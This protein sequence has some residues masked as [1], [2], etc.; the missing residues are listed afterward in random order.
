[1]G[2]GNRMNALLVEILIAVLFFALSATVILETFVAADRLSDSAGRSSEALAEAQNWAGR[3][4]ASENAA[5]LLEES[6]FRAEDGGWTMDCGE[7]ALTVALTE[8]EMAAG[9]MLSAE[10]RAGDGDGTL[11]TLPCARYFPGEVTP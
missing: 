7:F 3:I 2:K 6:G 11:V 9:T 1:M 8:T 10:I 4:Y 5:A